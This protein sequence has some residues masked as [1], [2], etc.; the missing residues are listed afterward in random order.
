MSLWGMSM[1]RRG[2]TGPSLQTPGEI[3]LAGVSHGCKIFDRSK[4]GARLAEFGDLKLPPTFLLRSEAKTSE[5]QCWLIWQED[6]E[7]GVSF[8][9]L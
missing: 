8:T 4:T 1:K 2:P 9:A 6:D 5:Q 7:A 3:I